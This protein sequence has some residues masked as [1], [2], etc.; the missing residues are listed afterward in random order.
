MPLVSKNN[1]IDIKDLSTGVY[2]IEINGK[3]ASKT[4]KIVKE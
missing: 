1:L 4:I 2:F 3:T